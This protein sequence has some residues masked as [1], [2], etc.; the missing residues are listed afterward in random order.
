MRPVAPTA[1]LP[2]DQ[3][4]APPVGRGSRF[5]RAAYRTRIVVR[6]RQVHEIGDFVLDIDEN[7]MPMIRGGGPDGWPGSAEVVNMWPRDALIK[8]GTRK[9]PTVGDGRRCEISDSPSIMSA[10]SASAARGGHAWFRTGASES[11]DL[12]TGGCNLLADE[13]QLARRRQQGVPPAPPSQ[14][15]WR[16]IYCHRR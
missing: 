13:E 9:L 14:T 5:P 2:Y 3:A 16:E 6:S 1:C 12:N 7:T 8:H 4:G 10:S 11:I 15:P